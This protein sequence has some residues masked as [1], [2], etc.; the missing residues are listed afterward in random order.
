MTY[1]ICIGKTIAICSTPLVVG[2]FENS[3]TSVLLGLN[4]VELDKKIDFHCL[5]IFYN[6]GHLLANISFSQ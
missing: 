1:C 3:T 4:L 2:A 6:Q 5:H